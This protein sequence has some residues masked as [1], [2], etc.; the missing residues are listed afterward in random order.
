MKKFTT[1][2]E[3]LLRETR[4]SEERFEQNYAEVLTKLDLIKD[5]LETLKQRHNTKSDWG[6][7]GSISHINNEL[8]DILT[9]LGVSIGYDFN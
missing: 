4:E 7:V 6:F 9:F 5:N 3:D 2:E 1:I 8:E